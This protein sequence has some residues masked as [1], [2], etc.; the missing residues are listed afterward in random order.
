LRQLLIE[1]QNLVLPQKTSLA[2]VKYTRR[3]ATGQHAG[4]VVDQVSTGISDV[5]QWVST[6]S[7]IGL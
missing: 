3:K 1:T 7:R 2:G 6:M 4:Q 5:P